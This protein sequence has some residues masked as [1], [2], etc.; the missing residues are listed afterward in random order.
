[1]KKY[2]VYIHQNKINGK[3]YVGITGQN[4][5]NRWGRGSTYKGCIHFYNAIKK[6]GWD[7]FDHIIVKSNLPEQ[8]A[9]TL[10]KILIKIYDTTNPEKGYNLSEGGDGF[11]GYHH[12]EESK[13]KIS[14]AQKKMKLPQRFTEG[15]TPWNKGLRHSEDAIKKM[16]ES[17]RGKDNNQSKSVLQYGE[18]GELINKYPSA[19]EAAL[20]LGCSADYLRR[21]CK[22]NKSYKNYVWKYE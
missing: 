12:T 4:P 10:E 19:K 16:S 13:E 17:H 7:G 6:Y 22:T 8:C 15:H 14:N 11:A 1:M 21:V 3:L 20:V 18:N 5:K 2:L 9:K